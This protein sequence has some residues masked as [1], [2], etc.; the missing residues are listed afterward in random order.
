MGGRQAFSAAVSGYS[1]RA[2]GRLRKC[3]PIGVQIAKGRLDNYLAELL[4][5][6]VLSHPAAQGRSTAAVPVVLGPCA[7]GSFDPSAMTV[8]RLKH[9]FLRHGGKRLSRRAAF[10]R[11]C[12]QMSAVIGVQIAKGRL[13]NYLAELLRESVLSHPAAQGRSTAAVPVVLGPCA[14]GSFDPS[15]MTVRRLKHAFLR[16][17]GKRLSRRAAFVRRCSQMSARG[18]V[19]V[20]DACAGCVWRPPRL[21]GR[22]LQPLGQT[23]CQQHRKGC[24]GFCGA[25]KMK[26]SAASRGTLLAHGSFTRLG[27]QRAFRLPFGAPA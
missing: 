6:S 20:T 8:R 13:D 7:A 11:R 19:M 27:S 3:V 2:R 15:A 1:Y 9:A 16:H 17:G 21:F 5:E 24:G 10:V 25:N 4:R 18:R 23:D 12:S 14:A 22:S 26:G